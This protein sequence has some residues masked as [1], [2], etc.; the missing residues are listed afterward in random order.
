M[1]RSFVSYIG[2]CSISSLVECTNVLSRH[3]MIF[4]FKMEEYHVHSMHLRC[5][6][7]GSV[8]KFAAKASLVSFIVFSEI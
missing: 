5:S 4:I 3:V 7:F 8:P 6:F 1:I 2:S